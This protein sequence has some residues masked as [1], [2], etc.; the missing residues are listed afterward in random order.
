MADTYYRIIFL[1]PREGQISNVAGERKIVMEQK[2][3][4][5]KVGGLNEG[6][7]E[8]KLHKDKK[9]AFFSHYLMQLWRS[10]LLKYKKANKK[11][12]IN[13]FL[14][15]W[16]RFIF[17]FPFFITNEENFSVIS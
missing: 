7:T 1:E 2:S 16:F 6:Y 12:A 8:K 10:K 5:D 17:Y 9:V 13:K 4:R 3:S 11:F 14:K 15:L